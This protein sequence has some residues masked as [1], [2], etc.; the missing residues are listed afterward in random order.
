MARGFMYVLVA[1]GPDDLLKVGMTHAPLQRWSAFHRRWFEV[2]DL[3]A[4][5]LVETETRAESQALETRLH[6]QLV[7]HGCPVPL[8]MQLAAGGAT[9]WYRGAWDIASH[10]V[11]DCERGGHVVH[12]GARDVLAPAMREQAT[13][14]HGLVHEAQALQTSGWLLPEQRNALRD[15]LDAHRAF[16]DDVDDL[17]LDD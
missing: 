13:K 15:L 2:F 12:R 9:E 11:H 10:F 4:S 3:D 7:D 14:L 6:R 1:T 5:L 8:T 17:Q 16:G